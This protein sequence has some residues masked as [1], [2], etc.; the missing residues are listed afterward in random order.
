MKGI[1]RFPCVCAK[2]N[3][4]SPRKALTSSDPELRKA[5]SAEPRTFTPIVAFNLD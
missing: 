1:H 2:R 3:V 4:K 5:V